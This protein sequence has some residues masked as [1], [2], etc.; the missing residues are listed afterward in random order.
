MTK[1]PNL[2]FKSVTTLQKDFSELPFGYDDFLYRPKHYGIKGIITNDDLDGIT[3]AL[4]Y[5]DWSGL[6][7]VGIFDY[8]TLWYDPR[9]TD[10]SPL[11]CVWL[12]TDSCDPKIRCIGNH[13]TMLSNRD[14]TSINSINMND[15]YD[16]HGQKFGIYN[17]HYTGSTAL[18]IHAFGMSK[19][20]DDIGR[21]LVLLADSTWN[22]KV[23]AGQNGYET[24]IDDWLQRMNLES[25]VPLIPTNEHGDEYQAFIDL[26][27]QIGLGFNVQ[28]DGTIKSGIKLDV[29][30]NILGVAKPD[31]FDQTLIRRESFKGK[32]KLDLNVVKNAS[33][34][35][36]TKR[37]LERHL[38][39]YGGMSEDS[40]IFNVSFTATNRIN[41][42][43]RENCVGVGAVYG[44]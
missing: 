42:N 32:T 31:I 30:S 24:F 25:L 2:P 12:D 36:L 39:Q 43:W 26:K 19:V 44:L 40:R 1:R 41:V 35:P 5:S 23:K 15:W 20:K 10:I 16:I 28:Y 27:R 37:D 34:T 8:K 29:I 6:P 33:G 17:H 22:N 14:F 13:T 38:K 18:M 7:I 4:M 21:R 3:S 11:D 9:H